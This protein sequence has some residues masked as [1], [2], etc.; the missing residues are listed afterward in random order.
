MACGSPNPSGLA[1]GTRSLPTSRPQASTCPAPPTSRWGGPTAASGKSHDR[2]PEAW[3]TRNCRQVGD[4]R[5]GAGVSPAATRI[6]R[7]VPAPMRWPRPGVRLGCAGAP[8]SGSAWPAAGPA[9]GS[10]PGS[11]GVPWYT[12][13]QPS[14]VSGGRPD[15]AGPRSR[16][17]AP[18][19]PCP[20]R[21]RSARAAPA[22]RTNR[23][24]SR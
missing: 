5:R 12:P 14:P 4:A 8:T 22:S 3:E 21:C 18:R 7:I 17:A 2:I 15:G 16:A 19:S 1:G 23:D 20:S 6:R 10:P 24:M 13:G 11:A 9:H